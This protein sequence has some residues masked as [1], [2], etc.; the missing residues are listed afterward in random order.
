[1]RKIRIQ[2]PNSTYIIEDDGIPSVGGSD[3]ADTGPTGLPVEPG[4]GAGKTNE[5][6]ARV[7]AQSFD[8]E[9]I[10]FDSG[11]FAIVDAALLDA[12][13]HPLKNTAIIIP[14]K[15]SDVTFV[16]SA[17][18][19]DSVLN[20]LTI[21]PKITEGGGMEDGAIAA[22][23]DEDV[24][25]PPGG[26]AHAPDEKEEPKTKGKVDESLPGGTKSHDSSLE[27][28]L[29]MTPT[30]R[31][32][33]RGDDSVHVPSPEKRSLPKR[34]NKG[35]NGYT[36]D[37]AAFLRENLGS[38]LTEDKVKQVADRKKLADTLHVMLA[39]TAGGWE[40]QDGHLVHPLG[41]TISESKWQAKDGY[42]FD[43]NG[44]RPDW[45]FDWAYA[46]RE[47]ARRA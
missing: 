24:V 17:Q 14:V 4:T 28:R 5:G 44:K 33:M 31:K 27:R 6:G 3:D 39:M 18:F 26:E 1:M 41:V 35:K 40:R 29:R 38:V 2:T 30:Q 12:V 8:G 19:D 36:E 15:A 37:I 42:L 20:G 7:L 22:T 23:Q 43:K 9:E 25:V 21:E 34:D 45:D 47:V 46:A 10:R 13:E 32:H 16:V 11:R